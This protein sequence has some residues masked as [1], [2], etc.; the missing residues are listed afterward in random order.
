MIYKNLVG[1]YSLD[2]KICQ[3]ICN[4]DAISKNLSDEW[5]F[6][7]TLELYAKSEEEIASAKQDMEKFNELIQSGRR[8][9]NELLIFKKALNDYQYYKNH[10]P[11]MQ[12]FLGLKDKDIQKEL[13]GEEVKNES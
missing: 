10:S 5:K 6:L 4:I 1:L 8:L 11:A 9:V 12:E 7:D 2:R 13:Q 3:M